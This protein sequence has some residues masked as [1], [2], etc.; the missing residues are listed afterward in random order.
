MNRRRVEIALLLFGAAFI[1][2]VVFS[3]RPVSRRAARAG[4]APQ[5]PAP[6][7][8]GP[9]TTLSSGFDFTESLKGRPL[10]RITAERTAG[11]GAA[12]VAGVAPELYVGENVA[13]NLYT[14][15]GEPVIVRAER[16]EYDARTRGATLEG[17]VRW[18]DDRGGLAETGRLFFRSAE[19][20]LEAPGTLRLSRGGFDLTAR[21]GRYDVESRSL[22]LAGPVEGRGTQSGK[23]PL[24][25]LRAGSGLYRREE[26]VI[27]LSGGVRAASGEG[28]SIESERLVLKLEE[29]GGRLAWARATGA[30]RG[31][32]AGQ[33]V[34]G[35]GG[36][37][38]PYSAEEAAFWLEP[39]GQLRSLTLSG[40]PA[41]AEEAGRRVTARTI[42]LE[43][44]GGRAVAA[45]A[46]GE[47][48]VT[49]GRD[50][51]YGESGDLSFGADGRV[52]GF[53]LSG[54]ARLEGEGRSARAQSAVE[55]PGR[56]VWI[57]T[58][59]ARASATLEEG[60]SRISAPRIE[61]DEEKKTVRAEGGGARVVLAPARQNRANAT[62]VG[63][64]SRPTFGK[65][66]RM[67]FDRK[68][69]TATLSGGAALW[70]EASS[71]FGRDITLN[72]LERSVVAVGQVRAI[73]APDPASSHPEE[74][75]PT[76]LTAARLLYR[77]IPGQ[78]SDTASGSVAL[79]GGLTAV[80][81]AWRAKGDSGTVLL[82]RDRKV[83]K[84]ELSG[85]VFLSD[86]ASGRAG[87]GE[88]ALD[89]P[90]EGRTVLEGRPAQVTDRQ[91]NRVAGATLTITERGRRVEVTAPEGGRT[92]TIH[93][94]RRD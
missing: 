5:I 22:A 21:S 81:G 82:G 49:S 50:R 79:E 31:T 9:A 37:A 73:L 10:F 27:E 64:P 1:A 61:I 28:D 59:D 76:V 74:G 57:L 19:R 41:C 71:L 45:R 77:E 29:P 18:E 66:D 32:V 11:F 91:G 93:P 56:G 39:S 68:A 70:Q 4:P 89:F 58:G 47:V 6:R 86:S 36:A 23:A 38:R 83:Q 15:S 85:S 60:G 54:R 78:A 65:A 51:A 62:L 26:G 80:R 87:Q 92:E 48:A 94:T 16:A 55:V 3:F 84:L 34:P 75:S 69:K 52:E 2:V 30:V 44:S 72:D 8:A 24:S 12:A 88:H 63:D 40:S 46:R 20:A 90:A 35:K 7:D 42:E 17:N 33:R 53:S 25:S 67:I 13:L 14:E 43:F